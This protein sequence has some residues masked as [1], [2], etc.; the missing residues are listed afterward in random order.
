MK[1]I[2]SNTLL[3]TL[4]ISIYSLMFYSSINAQE[5]VKTELVKIEFIGN[6][7]FDTS[8][9][10]EL[11]VSK[12][13]PWWGSQFFESFSNLGS[14]ASYFDSLDI[15]DDLTILKNYYKTHGFFKPIIEADFLIESN[16]DKEATLTFR[17]QEN[18][19]SLIR[20]Y[21][22]KGIEDL[23]EDLSSD[24]FNILDI[25]S[26]N[27][28]SE[29]LVEQNSS[30][31]VKF[32][33]DHGYMLIQS[34][35]P[36]VDIDTSANVVDVTSDFSLGNRF[37]IS[38]VN[39]EKGG[40]GKD[41]VSEELINDIADISP[42]VFYSYNAIKLAQVR[43]YR[44]N[45]FTSAVISGSVPDTVGQYV[46]VNIVTKVGMLNELSPEIILLEEE[47]TVKF[48]LGLSYVNKNFLG[49]ARKLTLGVSSAAQNISEFIQ[50]VNFST[51]GDSLSGYIDARVSIEQPFLFGK[52][53]NT[54]FETFYTLEKKKN[55]W[56]ASI[57]GAK[58]NLSFELPQYTF[59]TG[60]STHFI[61]Q[62]SRYDFNKDYLEDQFSNSNLS[63]NSN[64]D[65]L[66]TSLSNT[67]AISTSAILG[68]NLVSNNT[69]DLIFPTEGYSVSLLVEDGNSIPYLFSKI[70]NYNYNQA[71]YTKLV[72]TSTAYL[73]STKNIFDSFGFKIKIGNIN[74]YH[75]ELN[76]IPYN[77][78]FTAGGS[79]SLRGW[80]SNDL[81]ITEQID[82]P[83]NPTKD[84]F[85][86]IARN[87]TP[88]GFFLFEGSIEARE[89]LS[90]LI[91]MAFFVDYGNVWDKYTDLKIDEIAIA[92][93]FGF[94]FYLDIASIR[95]DFGFKTYDP[96]DKRSF[97]TRITK[98]P[99]LKTFKFQFGIG[100]A[101]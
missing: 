58:L 70:G 54:L 24:L 57:Y 9:L 40:P 38:E 28:F 20:N 56:N 23:S 41:L 86:N 1:I 5:D 8:D 100:E 78:R 91:G 59:L 51:D 22:I 49:D 66:I 101:F 77:Q 3:S 34:S 31:I 74:A 68:V 61:W 44:T 67:P 99:F 92:A 18:E 65:S 2:Y 64:I 27:R 21:N 79:N 33:Q 55:Q 76:E 87:I 39:V 60:L 71:A 50:G 29:K 46:P 48:G 62:H 45:L 88:G 25:D 63:E 85:E 98:S 26:T 30:N 47:Q 72:V 12:E 14:P 11:I 6:D 17:I 89:H 42:G 81:P 52:T 75:G 53:I 84:E 10:E 7:Y 32:L 96:E 37:R 69:D 36:T 80:G 95:L 43:L 15:E 94:R 93:G 83:Q 73:R 16:G 97:F 13:S 35:A 82:I 19:S 4:L 90:E